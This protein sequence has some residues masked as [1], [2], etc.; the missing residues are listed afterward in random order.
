MI[1]KWLHI[2]YISGDQWVSAIWSEINTAIRQGHLKRPPKI[3]GELSLHITTRLDM[4]PKISKRINHECE[5]LYEAIKNHGQEYV[6]TPHKN[7]F[8]YRIDDDL[9]FNLLLDINSFLFEINACCELIMD[10][11]SKIY[12]FLGQTLSK[13]DAGQKIKTLLEADGK[14]TDWF[15]LLDNHRNLFIHNITPY[16]AVDLTRENIGEYDVIVMKKNVSHFKNPKQYLKLSQLNEIVIGFF[17]A[18]DLIRHNIV[19]IIKDKYA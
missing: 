7:A 11:M 3:I 12:E 17:T 15:R 18:R 2:E 10:F 6:F 16:F 19:S 8:A 13:K 14:S 1:E 4:L 5:A 9:K